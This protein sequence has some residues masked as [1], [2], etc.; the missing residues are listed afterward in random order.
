MSL[1]GV[2]KHKDEDEAPITTNSVHPGAI[3]TNIFRHHNFFRDL[4]FRLL[5]P[6]FS[7]LSTIS[8]LGSLTLQA[9]IKAIT[10]MSLVCNHLEICLDGHDMSRVCPCYQSAFL[11]SNEFLD[12]NMWFKGY[13]SEAFD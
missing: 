10:H 7:K 6:S 8:G 3:S 4:A 5:E 2:Q 9:S 12:K 11:S 13:F 1:K